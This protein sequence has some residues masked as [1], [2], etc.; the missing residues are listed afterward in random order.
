M[1]QKS[2]KRW[3]FS[4]HQI[5]WFQR[6]WQSTPGLLPGKSHGQ[7][8]LVGYSPWGCKESDTTKRL[9]SLF[10]ITLAYFEYAVTSS[11]F[12]NFFN[13]LTSPWRPLSLSQYLPKHKGYIEKQ[14][15]KH[16][17]DQH[18]MP[19]NCSHWGDIGHI[20]PW[21]QSPRSMYSLWHL[22][23]FSVRMKVTLAF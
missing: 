11:L 22:A 2:V 12:I 1:S 4:N 20:S 10:S 13:L 23:H 18:L 19:L 21:Q 7:R 9:L 5:T 14:L 6:K 17:Q 3:K 8:S 16:S 15:W